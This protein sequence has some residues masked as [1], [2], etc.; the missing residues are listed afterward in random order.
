V[1]WRWRLLLDAADRLILDVSMRGVYSLILLPDGSLRLTTNCGRTLGTYA[2]DG[3]RLS[4]RLS[5][6][7]SDSCPTLHATQEQFERL[8]DEVAAYTLDERGLVLHLLRDTAVMVFYA[9]A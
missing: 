4:M 2:V 7:I 3:R 8:V 1:D 5:R 6:H 9:V